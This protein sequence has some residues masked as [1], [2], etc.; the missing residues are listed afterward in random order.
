MIRLVR[1]LMRSA[2]RSETLLH[3]PGAMV[4]LMQQ[5]TL[6]VQA[7][8]GWRVYCRQGALWLTQDGDRRDI[9]LRD[10]QWF[11]LNRDETT[12]IHALAFSSVSLSAPPQ[13]H[14]A[15]IRALAAA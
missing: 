10:G 12:L 2:H 6:R 4:D 9:I 5:Q 11:E 7:A 8:K 14:G 13:S 1:K 3:L 15:V